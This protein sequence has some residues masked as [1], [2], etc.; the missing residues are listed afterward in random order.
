MGVASVVGGFQRTLR[1]E[2]TVTGTG[3]HSGDKTSVTIRPAGVNSG[4]VF[5][6]EK[7]RVRG[8]VSNVID[9]S[10]GTTLGLNGTRVRTVEHLMAALRGTGVSNA[11]VEVRG[12]E[13]PILDGS[14]LGFVEAISSVGTVEQPEKKVVLGISEPVAVKSNGSFILAVPSK[15][16]R[17]TYVMRYEHPLI[18]SQSVTFVLH[19]KRFAEDIAPARTFVLYEELPGLKSQELAKGGSIANAI[20]VWQDRMSSDL[21]FQDELARHKLLD[22]VGDL[23]LLGEDL[24]ADIVAVKSGHAL[25]VEFVRKLKE[26]A[27]PVI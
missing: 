15:C 26:V 18:G 11:S 19:E 10:R 14:A 17:L 6:G 23:T 1:D 8:V 12:P 7:D 20:V 13:M 27:R 5:N 2:V 9:T 4:I 25:N 16:L 22:L 3:L 24:R 21:R